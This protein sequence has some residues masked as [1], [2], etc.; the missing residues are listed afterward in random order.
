[1]PAD[2]WRDIRTAVRGLRAAPGF[3]SIAIVSLALGIGINTAMFSVVNV[4]ISGLP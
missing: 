1:M 4:L 2:L 3:A